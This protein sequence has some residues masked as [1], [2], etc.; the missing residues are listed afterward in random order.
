MGIRARYWTGLI[1]PT[2]ARCEYL[3]NMETQGH[4]SSYTR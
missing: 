4:S 1:A 3:S 2:L